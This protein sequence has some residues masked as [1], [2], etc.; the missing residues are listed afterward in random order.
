MSHDMMKQRAAYLAAQW[1]KDNMLIG[2]GTGSTTQFFIDALSKRCHQG[3]SINAVCSSVASYQRAKDGGIPLIDDNQM[4]ALDMTF[5]GADEIDAQKRM[6]KGGGGALT[7]EKILANASREMVVLVDA[8]KK[9]HQLGGEKLPVEILPF[10]HSATIAKIRTLG[11]RGE[12][13]MQSAQRP[14]QT[15]NGNLI[16]DIEF[17]KPRSSPEKDH[18]RLIHIPGVVETGYF[19]NLA[20]RVLIGT[21][22]GEVDVWDH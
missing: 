1:V 22:S 16:Y 18:E 19:F 10:A 3:L 17:Q 9:V 5:D 11:F 14:F 8:T 21:P 2:I 6:I 20:G 13:R 15:D 7:R 12:L 4:T